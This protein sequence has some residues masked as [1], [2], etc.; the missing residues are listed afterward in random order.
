[1]T[2]IGAH[3]LIKHLLAPTTLGSAQRKLQL[4]AWREARVVKRAQ[5]REALAQVERNIAQAVVNATGVRRG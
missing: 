2:R 1:M 3:F 5:R 4:K